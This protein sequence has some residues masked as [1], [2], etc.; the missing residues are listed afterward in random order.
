MQLIILFN[1][2]LLKI[3]WRNSQTKL[4]SPNT[5]T[6]TKSFDGISAKWNFFY[7]KIATRNFYLNPYPDAVAEDFKCLIGK[8]ILKTKRI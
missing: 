2:M 7:L 4:K 8:K 1:N 6:E 5:Q 3:T